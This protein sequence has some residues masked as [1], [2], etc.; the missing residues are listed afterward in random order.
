MESLEADAQRQAGYRAI[1]IDDNGIADLVINNGKRV[2]WFK[3]NADIN[4]D[5]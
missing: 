2:K 1:V 3:L 4:Q 5:K